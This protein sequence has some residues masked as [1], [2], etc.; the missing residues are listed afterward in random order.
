[1]LKMKCVEIF[2]EAKS[3]PE[4]E[5]SKWGLLI[6]FSSFAQFFDLFVQYKQWERSSK[7]LFREWSGFAP[8]R[9]EFAVY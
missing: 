2:Y 3:F 9:L 7:Q 1:M 4:W 8:H 6:T 5:C